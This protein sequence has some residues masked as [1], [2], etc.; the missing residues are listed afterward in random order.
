EKKVFRLVAKDDLP[1]SAKVIPTM[2]VFDL[3]ISPTD[4]SIERFKARL[5][6]LGNRQTPDVDFKEI[7]SPVVSHTTIRCFLTF[8]ASRSM[9]VH[10]VDIKTAFLN[11]SL[12]KVVYVN[13]PSGL[14]LDGSVLALDK[15]L[16]GL[17]QAPKCWNEHFVKVLAD[18]GFEQLQVD[19]CVF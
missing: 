9:K 5:V 11:S 10:H 6:A 19:Q 2:W 15:A 18:L 4:Q 1:S 16:Y 13:P 17:R 8:A 14:D 3:K 7:F 12:D